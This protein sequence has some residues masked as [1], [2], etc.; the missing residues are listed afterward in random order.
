MLEY[1]IFVTDMEFSLHSNDLFLT[2]EANL[3]Y[4]YD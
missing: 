3:K 2:K 4:I 1:E